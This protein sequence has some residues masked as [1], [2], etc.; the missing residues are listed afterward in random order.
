MVPGTS[1]GTK[2]V[3]VGWKH[4][5]KNKSGEMSSEEIIKNLFSLLPKRMIDDTML[6]YRK[7]Y[8][9]FGYDLQTSIDKFLVKPTLNG[10]KN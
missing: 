1:N 6:H 2:E 4:K 8:E 5:A 7:D 3:N 10:T 9:A